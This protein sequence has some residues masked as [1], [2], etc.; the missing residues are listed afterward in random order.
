MPHN[1]I[2]LQAQIEMQL[3]LLDLFFEVAAYMQDTQISIIYFFAFAF[4]C[5]LLLY[6]TGHRLG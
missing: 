2:L 6:L 1:N 3:E 5:I 4:L